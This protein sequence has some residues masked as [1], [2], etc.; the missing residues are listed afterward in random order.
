MKFNKSHIFKL[1]FTSVL[2]ALNIVLE[3]FF[4]IHIESNHYSLSVITVAFAA[5]FL[6]TPYAIAVSALGDILG[7]LISPVGPYFPGFTLT[8]ILTALC[9]G[10]FLSKKVTLL[11]T[12]SA[13]IINK[14]FGT[15]ILNSIWV[16]ILYKGGIDAFPAYMITRIP[17]AIIMAVIEIAII[18]VIFHDKSHIRKLLSKSVNKAI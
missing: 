7:A 18:T 1:V 3:R 6:S 17:Q 2:I 14:I 8:N 11:N 13:I 12:T 15:L 5:V 4:T 9:I 10:L 16:S